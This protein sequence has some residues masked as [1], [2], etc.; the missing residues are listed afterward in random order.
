MFERFAAGARLAV[1]HAQEE[2]R[3]LGHDRIGVEHLLLGLLHDDTGPADVVLRS[4]GLTLPA[5]RSAVAAAVG[6]TEH[7][8]PRHLPFTP[9]AKRVLEKSLHAAQRL[10]HT[11]LGPGHLLLGLLGGDEGVAADILARHGVDPEDAGR[12]V[13]AAIAGRGKLRPPR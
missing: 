11:F 8:P 5:G 10:H 3:S 7:T 12:R 4:F 1:V 9:P 13:L 2:S 6:A